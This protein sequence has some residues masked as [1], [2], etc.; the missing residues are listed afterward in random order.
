[1][2]CHPIW[3]WAEYLKPKLNIIT[4]MKAEFIIKL[5]NW[6]TLSCKSV[7]NIVVS[8]CIL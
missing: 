5:L 7:P 3:E 1:M 2:F 6:I 8:E 4:S